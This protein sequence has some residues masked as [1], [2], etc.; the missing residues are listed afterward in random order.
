[1]RA[2]P[3]LKPRDF[4][5]RNLSQ[6]EILHLFNLCDAVWFHDGDPHK[7]HA[8]L[9]SGECSNGYFN[10]SL[11]LC[12]PNLN[13]ILARQLA[14]K[15]NAQGIKKVLWVIGSP[16]AAITF[17]YEV[18]KSLGARHVFVE[19]DPKD[20]TGKRM[21]WRRMTIPA[22]DEVLQAEELIT[23]AYTTNEVKRAV[24]EGN[25]GPVNFLP[26]VGALVHRPPKLPADHGGRR[27]VALIEKEIWAV[28][29]PCHL[30]RAGSPRYRP[31]SH[32]KELT[33]K[34]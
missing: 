31:K 6:E 17:S 14:R 29:P 27:V 3:D 33:G 11:V 13:E 4:E 20:P 8:E 12:Y 5:E 22:G 16:Y 21:V 10:C 18:A 9:V 2:P 26:T 25:S 30:C 24:E 1:M 32:W 34:S 7:P 28:E 23:T 15:L 19:K